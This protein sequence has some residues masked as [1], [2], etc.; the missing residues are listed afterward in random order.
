MVSCER[1][2]EVPFKDDRGRNLE[3]VSG[4]EGGTGETQVDLGTSQS[5]TT[6]MVQFTIPLKHR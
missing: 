2:G 4:P 6:T 5:W 1:I 3:L